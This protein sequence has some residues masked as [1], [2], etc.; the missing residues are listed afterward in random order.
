MRSPGDVSVG[1]HV[2]TTVAGGALHSV[3]EGSERAERDGSVSEIGYG[4]AMQE[5]EAILD[6]IEAEDVDVD[7][8]AAKVRRAAELVR[9]CRRRIHDTQVQVEQIV[10]GLD[11]PLRRIRRPTALAATGDPSPDPRRSLPRVIPATLDEVE[12]ALAA[13]RYVADRSLVVAIHLALQLRRPL[14]LEGEAGVGKTEVAKALA[15]IVDA[16]L[17]RLQCYEGLDVSQALYEWDYARQMLAIRLIEARHDGSHPDVSDIMSRDYLV[18]RPLLQAIEAGARGELTVLL[19]DELD[20]ADEEFEAYLLELLSDFQVTIPEVET[21]RAVER[22]LVV[23]TSNRTREIHDALKRRC[24]YHWIDYP[25]FAREARHPAAPV[26]GRSGAP[27]PP[28]GRH[29]AA[30][31]LAR[32]VQAARGGG[33]AR[34]GGGAHRAR[35]GRP[36]RPG[37]RRHAR[38]GTQVPGGHRQGEGARCRRDR[39]IGRR[40]AAT[41]RPPGAAPSA[42]TANIVHFVRYLPRLRPAARARVRRLALTDVID[43][44]G[45]DSRD[46]LYLALRASII[47]RTTQRPVFDQAFDLFFGAGRSRDEVV[48]TA[49]RAAADRT[50]GM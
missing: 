11:A 45:L 36:D 42:L 6:E 47:T 29:H 40:V 23:I 20:R 37:R 33:D 49:A 21:V 9:I 34:L 31:P 1:D 14:F 25:D 32:A 16:D 17:I 8:L 27:G 35:R 13:E 28:A 38:G 3:V 26:P 10:A 48:L 18:A 24:L 39:R 44:V 7:V 5:L 50:S 2:V 41:G 15:S 4:E 46:D 43:V 19:I 12:S 22:P 30:T